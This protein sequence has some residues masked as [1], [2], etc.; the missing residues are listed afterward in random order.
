MTETIDLRNLKRWL[1]PGEITE[2]SQEIGITTR[3]ASRIIDGTHQNWAFVQKFLER[4]ERN[5]SIRE[6][7]Q[8]I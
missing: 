8:A 2:I 7:A 6:R 3:Q 5:K 1:G 4:V